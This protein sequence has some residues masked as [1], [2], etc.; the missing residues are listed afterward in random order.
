MGVVFLAEDVRL[1]RLVALKPMRPDVADDDEAGAR[2]LREAQAMAAVKHDHVVTIHQVGEAGGVP[3]LAMEFLEGESLEERL[4]HAGKLPLGEVLRIGREVAEGLAAAHARGLIHRHVQPGNIWL[5]ARPG[6]PGASAT[7]GRV[8][9]LDFGL[10]RPGADAMHLTQHGVIVGTPAYMAPEQARG[11]TVDP[12]ADL[13]SRGCVLY[14]MATGRVPFPGR[15]VMSVLLALT[16]EQPKPPQEL[17]PVVSPAANDFILRL[18]A[19]EPAARPASARAVAEALVALEEATAR[20]G[21]APK[22]EAPGGWVPALALG[23]GSR[24]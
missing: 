7:G 5:E 15:D 11:E 8:K 14:R 2:F 16:T 9:I 23:V 12:R 1:K 3:F 21:P 19:K 20:P 22:P 24:R 6:E 13:F 4:K 10:V 17:N 18:L